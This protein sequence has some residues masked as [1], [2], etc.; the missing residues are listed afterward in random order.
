MKKIIVNT[1]G[2][3]WAPELAGS[4]WL[5]LQYMLGFQRLGFETFWVDHIEAFEPCTQ[6]RGLGYFLRRFQQTACEFGFSDRF[7]IV[8]DDSRE[9]V[10][11]S[12]AQFEMVAKEA[13]LLITIGSFPL[14]PGPL[15]H[16]PRRALVDVDPA[17]TQI[18]ALDTDV[19]LDDHNFWFTVGQNVGHPECFAPTCNRQWTSTYPP[20]V[21]DEWPAAIDERYRRFT[22]IADWR[23][24]QDAVFG[25]A[26][27]GGKSS[28]F[29]RVAQLPR[30]S[31]ETIELALLIHPCEY[32]DAR[33]MCEGGWKIV[34][35]FL[36]AGDTESYREYIQ[37]SR[38]EFSVA[39]GGYVKSN[40]GWISDRT[41]CYLASGKPALVQST[42]LEKHL[43]TGKGLLTF[44]DPA[45]A[46]TGIHEINRN[47]FEH[48]AAARQLAETHFSSDKVLGKILQHV[49]L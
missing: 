7:C 26:H 22:T 9:Y 11:M 30:V 31:G 40:S 25:G 44:R 5:R 20:I 48:C 43:P 6:P 12:Q 14:P 3:S 24:S 10:G 29:L 13:D 36:Y 46:I 41:V 39:K 37:N 49:G 16:I 19:G 18:W 47:Y 2:K 33:V 21:L 17:F 28:E 23:G 27:Y 45:D 42:G 8:L 35:P 15:Q 34:D 1:V 4:I 38:A 32:D